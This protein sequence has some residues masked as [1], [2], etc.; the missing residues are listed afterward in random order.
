MRFIKKWNKH[1][2]DRIQTML[3]DLGGYGVMV[4]QAGRVWLRQPPSFSELTYEINSLGVQSFLIVFV[5]SLSTGLVLAIQFGF[6]LERFGAKYY[7]PKIV[8]TS[9][10][11]ELGPIFTALMLSGRVG[12]GMAAEIASM[13]VTQ[14]IDAIRALGTDPIRKIIA[15]KILALAIATPFL[16]LLADWVG[17]F[18][19]MLAASSQLGLASNDYFFKSFEIMTWRDITGGLFKGLVFGFIIS[20]VSC[21]EGYRAKGGTLGVGLATTN[22][23]V[24]SSIVVLIFDFILT[25]MLWMLEHA[26]TKR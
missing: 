11:R 17:I 7:V 4:M 16:T 24:K 10:S 5:A 19:G 6:G 15:P 21:F 18:G 2:I 8:A 20:S 12:A 14:Q 9:I 25:K 1:F 23:V 26:L 3:S 13:K 22:A